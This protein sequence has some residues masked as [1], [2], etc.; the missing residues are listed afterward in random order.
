MALNVLT[1]WFDFVGR[2]L[3]SVLR[4][5][6]AEVT[7]RRNLSSNADRCVGG[8]LRRPAGSIVCEAHWMIQIFLIKILRGIRERPSFPSVYTWRNWDISLH[9]CWPL[10]VVSSVS[11]PTYSIQHT[12]IKTSSWQASTNISKSLRASCASSSCS[13]TWSIPRFPLCSHSLVC[14]EDHLFII[15]I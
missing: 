4:K 12:E 3:K 9:T 5:S 13:N 11:V 1:I 15:G 6:S 8:E 7:Q 2:T 10:N 14:T